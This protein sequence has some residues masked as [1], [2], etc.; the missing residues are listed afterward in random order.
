MAF[1]LLRCGICPVE[2]WLSGCSSVAL[3][4][5]SAVSFSFVDD[6]VIISFIFSLNTSLLITLF[7]LVSSALACLLSMLSSAVFGRFSSFFAL[8]KAFAL[9]FFTVFVSFFFTGF[10]SSGLK[11]PSSS[12]MK[13]WNPKMIFFRYA[14]GSFLPLQ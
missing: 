9:S 5:S 11:N 10:S 8:A 4:V 12:S 14:N 7:V 2:L 1:A 13:S 3:Q 6:D